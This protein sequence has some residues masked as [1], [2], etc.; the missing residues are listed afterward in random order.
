MV[1]AKSRFIWGSCGFPGNSHDSIKFQ[2][3]ELWQDIQEEDLISA[4]HQMVDEVPIPSMILA[5]SSFALKNWLLKPST[6]AICPQN[7]AI[8]TTASAGQEL[9]LKVP[10][11]NSKENFVFFY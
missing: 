11:V 9:S 3:A 8:S 1:D 5:D 10:M 6:N 4:I 2:S 7:K